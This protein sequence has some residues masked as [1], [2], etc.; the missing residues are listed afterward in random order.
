ML[1]HAAVVVAEPSP[2]P[3]R[4]RCRTTSAPQAAI[5]NLWSRISLSFATRWATYGRL[6]RIVATSML[7]VKW[8][9]ASS[10]NKRMTKI[11]LRRSLSEPLRMFT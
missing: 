5:G 8:V 7:A 9:R 1:S 3:N 10:E 11:I 2:T 4:V 6:A